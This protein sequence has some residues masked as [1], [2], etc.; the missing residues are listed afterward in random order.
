MVEE[1]SGKGERMGN[2]VRNQ[3]DKRM[4]CIVSRKQKKHIEFFAVR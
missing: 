3:F 1:R 4:R 2:E